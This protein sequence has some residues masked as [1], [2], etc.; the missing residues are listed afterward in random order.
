MSFLIIMDFVH[1]CLLHLCQ[2]VA[3]RSFKVHCEC[4]ASR[5]VFGPLL[6]LHHRLSTNML[7]VLFRVAYEFAGSFSHVCSVML[8]VV[9]M[10]TRSLPVVCPISLVYFLAVQRLHNVV[11]RHGTLS[12]VTQLNVLQ[13]ISWCYGGAVQQDFA[14]DDISPYIIQGDTGCSDNSF[15]FV[16]H[17]K[18]VSTSDYDVDSFIHTNIPLRNIVHH[19]PVKSIL[20][21]ARVHG[22]KISSHIPKSMMVTYFDAHHCATCT[23]ATTIFSI[24][25]GKLVRDRI[26]K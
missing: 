6:L 25:R 8:S 15:R 3:G 19:L 11:L 17:D 13:P 7:C 12:F 10:I 23:D 1:V 14:F 22:L 24:V 2:F 16:V 9:T 18:H 5:D 20:D 26:R 4:R 21:I